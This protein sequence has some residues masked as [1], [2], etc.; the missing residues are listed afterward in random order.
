MPIAKPNPAPLPLWLTA[1]LAAA[2]PG[3]RMGW[4]FALGLN[5]RPY[6]ALIAASGDWSLRL[7]VASL[8]LPLLAAMLRAPVLMSLRRMLGLHGALYAAVHLLA[9]ARQYGFDWPFL[10]EEIVSRLFLA[11]GF[12]AVLALV[13][14]VATST[15]W[16]HARLGLA[17]WRR[18][19][20]LIY[21]A[22]I[23]GLVH[24]VLSRRY[25][26]IEAGVMAGV[27]VG[28]LAWRALGP[29]LARAVAR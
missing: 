11:L 18:I 8:G 26:G 4:E 14:L 29:R 27:I 22:A 23:L 19:H 9:W 15:A 6:A 13:P 12:L 5:A 16:A 2:W 24:Q 1:F 17:R 28:A 3:V 21:P 20:L 7:I 10:A 25:S